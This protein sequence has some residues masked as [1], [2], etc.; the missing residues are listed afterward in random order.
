MQIQFK[1]EE[2]QRL[3][4]KIDEAKALVQ[5]A[6]RWGLA[7]ILQSVD[8]KFGISADVVLRLDQSIDPGLFVA[9]LNELSFPVIAQAWTSLIDRAFEQHFHL[10][11]D[12]YVLHEFS[13]HRVARPD[14][15]EAV[16]SRSLHR[17]KVMLK[18]GVEEQRLLSIRAQQSGSAQTADLVGS[19]LDANGLLIFE[20]GCK[21]TVV[22][23]RALTG[24][25]TS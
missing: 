19:V 21:L 17:P 12:R 24:E 18:W 15:C 16:H 1:V 5:T 14:Y 4:A 10:S 3:E 23:A 13:I 11:K 22:C 2:L 20:I 9:D 7:H 8:R 25:R 6:T